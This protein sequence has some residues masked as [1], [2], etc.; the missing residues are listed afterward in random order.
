V[1]ARRSFSRRRLSR[2]GR[3]SANFDGA[4]ADQQRREAGDDVDRLLQ[5]DPEQACSRPTRG[6]TRPTMT[7]TARGRLAFGS[8]ANEK[9]TRRGRALRLAQRQVSD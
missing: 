4:Q 3:S 2:A 5:L 9:R 6:E 8:A 7:I 1:P